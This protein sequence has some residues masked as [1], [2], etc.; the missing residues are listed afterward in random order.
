M[1]TGRR[2][3]KGSTMSTSGHHT[4]THLH[5]APHDSAHDVSQ[6]IAEAAAAC[7][8][9]GLRL[10]DQRREVLSILAEAPKP[11]GAYDILS[12]MT[13]RG[14]RKLAPVTVYRALDFL[15]EADLIHRLES[16]NAFVLCPHHHDKSEL[17]V[18][19]ICDACGRV[20]EATSE[21]V[22]AG[23]A[24]IAKQHQFALRGQVVEM[25]GRCTDCSPAS[26]VA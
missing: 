1:L 10:T 21:T 5:H 9:R 7:A 17:V 15:L 14:H 2:A 11:L 18:F 25:E 20:E 16:R 22:R 8:K 4:H 3:D 12:I 24:D 23:L 13:D 6:I 26:M 19:L